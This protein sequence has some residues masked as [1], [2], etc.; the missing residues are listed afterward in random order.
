MR[1]LFVC[2]WISLVAGCIVGPLTAPVVDR[3]FE[4]AERN[5]P[6]KPVVRDPATVDLGKNAKPAPTPEI[7]RIK[8]GDT[9]YSIALE[10]GLDYRDVASWNGIT[11]PARIGVGQILTMKNPRGPQVHDAEPEPVVVES[12]PFLPGE[13]PSGEALPELAPAPLKTEPKARKVPYS[14]EAFARMQRGEWPPKA[15]VPGSEIHEKPVPKPSTKAPVPPSLPGAVL[16]PGAEA[17]FDAAKWLWPAQG[18]IIHGFDGSRSKG[19]SINGKQ[20]DPVLASAAGKVVYTGKAI[21]A[22][23]PLVIVKHSN[24]YLSVYAHNSKILVKDGQQVTPGQKIAEMGERSAGQAALHFEIRKQGQPVD[25]IK[26]LP[27]R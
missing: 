24:E 3:T 26:F 9:L 13:L 14:P 21:Q 7:Y 22:Y 5:P 12:K 16:L 19:I 10:Y 27:S 17:G 8:E 11:D 2:A 4:D 23:G 1:R 6:P 15:P 18:D 20:G 25:P